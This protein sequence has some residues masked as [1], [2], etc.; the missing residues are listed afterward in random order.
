MLF[1]S[2]LFQSE[3][4]F[5]FLCVVLAHKANPAK[6]SRLP[7][8]WV[9]F[10]V[11]PPSIYWFHYPTNHLICAF[12]FFLSFWTPNPDLSAYPSSLR[13]SFDSHFLVDFFT[14]QIVEKGI[15]NNLI[16][17]ML[18]DFVSSFWVHLD[19]FAPA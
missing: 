4:L 9:L 1:L 18:L 11:F 13:H 12:Q 7:F 15:A 8:S 10:I 5:P 14:S 19:T 3:L 2:N 16:L 6:H 17:W